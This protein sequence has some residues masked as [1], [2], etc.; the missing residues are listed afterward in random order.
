MDIRVLKYFLVVS[1]TL[2]LTKA[3]EILL[4]TQPNLSRQ[5]QNLEEEI[6][7]TL[8]LRDSKKMVLTDAGVFFKKKAEE[9]VQLFDKNEAEI[10]NFNHSNDVIGEIYLGVAETYTFSIIAKV[11]KKIQEEN[12]N[13]KFNIFS[14]GLTDIEEKLENNLIDFGLVIEPFKIDKYNS[15]KMPLKDEWGLL[16][17]KDMPLANK[18][19]INIDDLYDLPLLM[20]RHTFN[21]TF[22]PLSNY[23]DITK[24]NI[25]D[26]YNLINNVR[27]LALEKVGYVVSIDNLLCLEPHSNLKF[28]PFN[29]KIESSNYLIYKKLKALNKSSLMFL[30]YLRKEIENFK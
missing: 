15:I 9:I 29:P 10:L 6:N 7:Q 24:L 28:I 5:I 4:T 19:F 18:K 8:F 2:N 3:A 27:Y 21:N 14:S 26:T 16:M 23:L 22:H 20:S 1:E 13:I 17:H 25:V 30:D 12:K 11:I